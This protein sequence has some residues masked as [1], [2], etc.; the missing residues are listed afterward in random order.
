MI[1]YSHADLEMKERPSV[2]KKEYHGFH[3]EKVEISNE[4]VTVASGNSCLV[5]DYLGVALNT[6]EGELCAILNQDGKDTIMTRPYHN[7]MIG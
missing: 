7:D 4:N 6:M 3:I 5:Y 2:M 1:F